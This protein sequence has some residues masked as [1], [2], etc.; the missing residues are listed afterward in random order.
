MWFTVSLFSGVSIKIQFLP[1]FLP[2]A[3]LGPL[4]GKGCIISGVTF[5][6]RINRADVPLSLLSL[7]S[8]G[9]LTGSV[10]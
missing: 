6:L 2:P 4:L 3:F 10:T 7:V 5:M 9:A 1:F 8:E